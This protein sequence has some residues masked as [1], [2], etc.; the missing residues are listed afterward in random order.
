MEDNVTSMLSFNDPQYL[1]ISFA[2]FV[3]RLFKLPGHPADHLEGLVALNQT[4]S[5]SREAHFFDHGSEV[6]VIV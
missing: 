3:C 4:G 1:T 2:R 6:L 5:G